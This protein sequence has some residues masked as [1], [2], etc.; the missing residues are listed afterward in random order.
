MEESIHRIKSDA[1]KEYRTGI[2][3]FM[4]SAVIWGFIPIYWKSL[5]PISTM[6][7][8]LYRI[9]LTGIV[10]WAAAMRFYGAEALKKPWTQK[11][12][13]LKVFAAGLFITTNWSTYIYAVSEQYVIQLCLGFYIQ[14]LMI[15]AFG[16]VL[17]KERPRKLKYL[18]LFLAFCGVVIVLVHFREVPAVA[19]IIAVTFAAYSA[20]KRHLRMEALVSLFYESVFFI[21][22]ALAG[23]VYLEISGSGALSQGQPHQFALL[24]ISGVLT[25]IPLGLFTMAANRIDMVAL[26][27]LGYISPSIVLLLGIFLFREPFDLTEFIA[28]FVIWVGLAVFAY[29]EARHS[30]KRAVPEDSTQTKPLSLEKQIN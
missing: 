21:P 9:V 15:C 4:I 10:A 24:L 29:D 14:P 25:A 30:K 8:I 22:F 19:L 16:I 3:C 1:K 2:L 6:M 5:M 20:L 7:I 27:I 11:G 17:F 26:G 13:M 12:A 28:F 23:I 18:S